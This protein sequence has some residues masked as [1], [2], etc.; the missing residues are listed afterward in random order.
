MFVVRPA[1]CRDGVTVI[2]LLVAVVV[3]SIL[4]TLLIGVRGHLQER[5]HRAAVLNDLRNYQT[6][7]EQRLASGAPGYAPS[8]GA[9]A[10]FA[11]SS[12]VEFRSGYALPGHW[13]VL[14]GHN[15]SE[16][17]CEL[18]GGLRADPARSRE[19]KCSERL[20]A[21][22]GWGYGQDGTMG[23]FAAHA[24][25]ATSMVE[26]L[27]SERSPAGGQIARVS[28]YRWM[29]GRENI[30]YDP[31]RLY[32]VAATLRQVKDPTTTTSRAVYVG[33]VGIAENG[34]SWIN[35]E[36]KNSWQ[37]QHYIAA[38]GFI[39]SQSLGWRTFTGYASGWDVP[40]YRTYPDPANPAP[41][42][43]GVKYVRPVVIVNYP[44]VLSDG[45]TDVADVKVEIVR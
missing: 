31:G 16:M 23:E 44:N 2:E 33:L 40:L 18:D 28:G 5:A 3:V 43:I 35:Y 37:R 41:M 36:G 1:G 26:A 19:P 20:P 17:Q 6:A 32:R 8:A 42:Y 13:H 24:G 12:G 21:G 45:V 29:I 10:G 25:A 15:K 7:Q 38:H 4:A 14:L 11:L 30:P 34:T 22:L 27:P 39:L 9:L